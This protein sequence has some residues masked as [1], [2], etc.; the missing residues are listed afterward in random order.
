MDRANPSLAAVVLAVTPG[1]A[2]TLS[3]TKDRPKS[4]LPVSPKLDESR[5]LGLEQLENNWLSS[6]CRGGLLLEEEWLMG[7]VQTLRS[8]TLK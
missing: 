4:S 6:G 7:R 2:G 3:E 8:G 1:S 5:N